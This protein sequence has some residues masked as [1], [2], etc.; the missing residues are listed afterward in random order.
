MLEGE[1]AYRIMSSPAWTITGEVLKMVHDET[2]WLFAHAQQRPPHR[3]GGAD[4]LLRQRRPTRTETSMSLRRRIRIH[5]SPAD[6]YLQA[7]QHHTRFNADALPRVKLSGAQRL[8]RKHRICRKEVDYLMDF[9]PALL[10]T[11]KDM[12]MTF[13][14]SS[15]W[16]M[17]L[18]FPSDRTPDAWMIEMVVK[19]PFLI[20]KTYSDA[21]IFMGNIATSDIVEIKMS[22]HL[23]H[24]SFC[25]DG[26]GLDHAAGANDK[27]LR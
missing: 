6:T 23:E 10:G 22:Y 19:T 2:H 15:V 21:R 3:E 11:S 26:R 25:L 13:C 12:N 7:K 8:R 18:N 20:I 5:L 14:L 16:R 27:T 4:P 9:A 1:H 24:I 17:M